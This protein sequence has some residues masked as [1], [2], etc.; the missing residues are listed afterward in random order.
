[1]TFEGF[2][3]TALIWAAAFCFCYLLVRINDQSKPYWDAVE[4]SVIG[5]SVLTLVW[6]CASDCPSMLP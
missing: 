1:M 3:T 4:P 6:L 2:L 5:A